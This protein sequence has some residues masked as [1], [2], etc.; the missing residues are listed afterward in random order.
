[1][2][3]DRWDTMALH[4]LNNTAFLNARP[5]RGAGD[6]FFF[7]SWKPKAAL[8][9][10]AHPEMQLGLIATVAGLTA[11]TL[12]A[13][14]LLGYAPLRPETGGALLVLTLVSFIAAIANSYRALARARVAELRLAGQNEAVERAGGVLVRWEL[15]TGDLAWQGNAAR[16]FNTSPARVPANLRDLQPFLV[17]RDSF[18]S[19]ISPSVRVQEKERHVVW[20]LRF[21]DSEKG[22]RSFCFKGSVSRGPRGPYFYGLLLPAPE[23][24]PAD[25][26]NSFARLTAILESL[27]ISVAIWDRQGRLL[28]C[29]RKFRK[30]YRIGPDLCLPSASFEE[31]QAKAGEPVVQRPPET[32]GRAGRLWLS[33]RQLGDGTWLQVGEYWMGDGTLVSV[34][35][36][37]TV[38]KLGERQVLEREQEMRAKVDG[39]E[40]SRRQ[41]EIQARQLRELAESYN[42]EKIRAEAA[43][44]AKSE[45]LAN[46]S[47]ELRT[48]LN[49]IIGFSEMMRD[50]VLGPIGNPKY[51]SYVRDIYA[52][53]RYLLEMI[54]DILDMSKIEAG[55]TTL[56]PECVAL[57]TV[58]EE[59]LTVVHPSSIEGKV[60]LV[61]CGNANITVFADKRA[62]KQI[63]INLLS[64]AIKFTPPGGKVVLR[65][66]RYRG[67]LRIAITDTGVGIAK[68]DLSRL[69]K[70]FEQVGNQ[71]TKGHKGTGLGLAISRS[72]VEMHGGKLD[73]KSRVGEGT[74]VTCILPLKDEKD[75]GQEA[76]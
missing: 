8:T 7:S 21:K 30:L 75:V 63:L 57:G 11:L 41:L 2:R 16:L 6:A 27:P 53:G 70:P 13:P 31:V 67:C 38:S 12:A 42:E 23:E 54:N 26:D 5:L 51:E 50:G 32:A 65:A 47:H 55:R 24:A 72:L 3:L 28:L 49:A 58:I 60:E 35:T 68:H 37:I 4:A 40:Q 64:N 10:L 17:A 43:N 34:G 52:S 59:C 48:P 20:P 73:I 74:T 25:K 46:V 62:L 36:D 14:M 15:A 29:N 69:G 56:S 18:Y 71:L 9:P 61:R 22:W 66:H 1:M 45:F 19:L 33:D 44:R 39:F 76:A